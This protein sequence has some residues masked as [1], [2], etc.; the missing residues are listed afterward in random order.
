M[1]VFVYAT[2]LEGCHTNSAVAISEY[3]VSG[4]PGAEGKALPPT[5]TWTPLI[6]APL[7]TAG[8]NASL[9][10]QTHSSGSLAGPGAS[11]TSSQTNFKGPDTSQ[12]IKAKRCLAFVDDYR[13]DR[14]TKIEALVDIISTVSGVVANTPGRRV[15]TV[16]EPYATMLDRWDSEKAR[17]S[18]RSA[19]RSPLLEDNRSR[20]GR[21][22][23]GEPAQKRTKLD[24]SFIGKSE[25]LKPLS[26][27]LQRTNELLANWSKD[28]KE[29][30]RRLMYHS[31]SPEFHESGW[32]EIIAGRCIDLDIVHTIIVTSRAVEKHTVTIGEVEICFGT[33]ATMKITT[34]SEWNAAWNRAA[35]ALRFAFP[36]RRAELDAYFEYI[37]GM[38]AQSAKAAH[39]KIILFDKAVRNRVGS[40]RRYELCDFD[41]FQDIHRMFFHPV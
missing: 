38:F 20:E 11:G 21:T 5:Y 25:Q 41:A 1:A 14:L 37:S 32:E 34:E 23:R 18:G 9:T 33:E 31:C 24:F 35:R 13:N 27:N 17:V 12:Q 40:S 28:Q 39:G 3:D 15:A 7:T 10:S 19:D 30:L 8:N 16:A 4:F 29:V 22:E 2:R 36:H 26:A 6:K